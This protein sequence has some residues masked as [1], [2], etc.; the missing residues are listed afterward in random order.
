[1][2]LFFVF[3]LKSHSVH[4]C[5]RDTVTELLLSMAKWQLCQRSY[6][7]TKPPSNLYINFAHLRQEQRCDTCVPLTPRSHLSLFINLYSCNANE[8]MLLS[9][10]PHSVL[11]SRCF[12]RLMCLQILKANVLLFYST[13]CLYSIWVFCSVCAIKMT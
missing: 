6:F 5:K 7:R 2:L 3:F 11:K 4:F 10:V 13:W 12:T 9:E 8:W 1:M